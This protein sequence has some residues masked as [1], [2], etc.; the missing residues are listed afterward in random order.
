MAKKARKKVKKKTTKKKRRRKGQGK[1]PA[2]ERKLC[3]LFSMWWT[4][5]IR[6]DVFWRTSQSGGRAT[7]RAKTSKTTRG[8]YGD[9]GATDP[10]GDPLTQLCVIEAKKGYNN[11]SFYDLLDKPKPTSIYYKWIQKLQDEIVC[12]HAPYWLLVHRRD[13][14]PYIVIMPNQLYNKIKIKPPRRVRIADDRLGMRIG[15]TAMLLEHFFRY[16]RPNHIKKWAKRS[17]L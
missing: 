13:H 5:G 14:R 2:F 11:Q 1:G 9:I 12:G 3:K 10:I 15:C 6:D 7:T 17:K 4:D 16:V 8:Q